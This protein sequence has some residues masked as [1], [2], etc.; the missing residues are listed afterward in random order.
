VSRQFTVA[1]AAL[2]ALSTSSLFI[3]APADTEEI[4]KQIDAQVR[5]GKIVFE[6]TCSAG[7]CH[8][9]GGIG[10]RAPALTQA[11]PQDLITNTVLNGRPGTPMPAF[12]GILDSAVLAQV[13]AYVCS[14]S[15]AGR[16][17]ASIVVI[18]G[19]PSNASSGP[20]Q[21][22]TMPWLAS[23]ASVNPVAI[24][25][26]QGIPAAGAALFFDATKLTSCH[27]CH[28]YAGAGGPIGRDL[29]ST[30]KTAV[31]ICHVISN[32][33]S[34]SPEYAAVRITLVDGSS[35]VGIEREENEEILR[36]YDVSSLPPILR[37]LRKAAV[38]DVKPLT[39]I[40]IYDH[41]TLPYTKQD[42]L[43]LCAFLGK[44]RGRVI[45]RNVSAAGQQE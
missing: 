35:S 8:G 9:A 29:A 22:K 34:A 13:I 17:P 44:A 20:V 5:A 10:G 18:R 23:N 27:A 38:K 33:K 1:C 4:Q 26:E 14:L 41:T 15:S 42:R 19:S 21:S 6:S 24:D 32:R 40:G 11:I 36:Y 43:S 30:D 45:G 37:T 7:S 2:A 39:G 28:S 12:K 3:S 25:S 31:E 16:Q